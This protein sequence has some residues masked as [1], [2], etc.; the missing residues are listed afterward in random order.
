M[1]IRDRYKTT[2]RFLEVFGLQ[3]LKDLPPMPEVLSEEAARH[4]E[5]MVLL[6]M[7]NEE[8]DPDPEETEERD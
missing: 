7:E 3:S 4:P 5:Q 2:A 6:P 1:C 8:S